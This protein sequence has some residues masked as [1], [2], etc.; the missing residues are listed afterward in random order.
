MARQ[1]ALARDVD[2]VARMGEAV[3]ADSHRI[4]ERFEAEPSPQL[5]AELLDAAQ[6][7]QELADFAAR[8]EV[9]S[10]GGATGAVAPAA[11]RKRGRRRPTAPVTQLV[12]PITP[13]PSSGGEPRRPATTSENNPPSE[14]RSAA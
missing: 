7:L 1:A 6:K 14:A 3:L 9:D 2:A 12:L 4:R 10:L 5:R 11:V 8:A 13:Q